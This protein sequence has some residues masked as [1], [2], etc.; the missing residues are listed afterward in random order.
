[1]FVKDKRDLSICMGHGNGPVHREQDRKYREEITWNKLLE[2]TLWMTST[3]GGTSS[4][5]GKGCLCLKLEE[6]REACSGGQPPPP[7]TD[8]GPVGLLAEEGLRGVRK[9]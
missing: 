4:T 1:M 5:L 8:R 6:G 7:L 9:V 2:E 3:G